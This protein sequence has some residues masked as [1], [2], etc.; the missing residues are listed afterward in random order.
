MTSETVPPTRPRPGPHDRFAALD[1]DTL[2]KLAEILNATCEPPLFTGPVNPA[3]RDVH[4][5]NYI[6]GRRSVYDDVVR[7]ISAKKQQDAQ[8][9]RRTRKRR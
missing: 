5:L 1:I 6:L 4:K 7:A 2:N 3:E 8:Q 9:A